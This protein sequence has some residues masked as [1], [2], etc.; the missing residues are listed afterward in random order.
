MTMM[1]IFFQDG[2]HFGFSSFT[3]IFLVVVFFLFFLYYL[4][5]PCSCQMSV[6]LLSAIM[7]RWLRILWQLHPS[8]RKNTWES[9]SPQSSSQIFHHYYFYFYYYSVSFIIIM[10]MIIVIVSLFARKYVLFF[11]FFFNFPLYCGQFENV[12][13]F[14]FFLSFCCC[15]FVFLFFNVVCGQTKQKKKMIIQITLAFF[16]SAKSS[17]CSLSTILNDVVGYMYKLRNVWRWFLPLAFS[18]AI[19]ISIYIP[20]KAHIDL[21]PTQPVSN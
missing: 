10:I 18:F 1:Y 19:L 9:S 4:L 14:L 5:V 12:F 3:L 20:T 11:F 8:P 7:W 13:F 17:L 6:S 2:S 21:K 15:C 16:S